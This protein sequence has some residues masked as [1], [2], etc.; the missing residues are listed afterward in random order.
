VLTVLGVDAVDAKA[1]LLFEEGERNLARLELQVLYEGL[2]SRF[3]TV[4]V[5]Q[6]V[7]WTRRTA[8]RHFGNW[9]SM[10]L[11]I[12]HNRLGPCHSEPISI[13]ARKLMVR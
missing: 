5:A 8:H 3:G 6:P 2:L 13:S 1:M 4:R 7:E 10:C 12:K 11:G 9:P